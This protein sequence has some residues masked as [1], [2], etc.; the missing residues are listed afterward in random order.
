METEPSNPAATPTQDTAERTGA[1]LP[2]QEHEAGAKAQSHRTGQQSEG[3]EAAQKPSE[4]QT[5]KVYPESK[6]E[7]SKNP[8]NIEHVDLSKPAESS[9]APAPPLFAR[10]D[11]TVAC[12]PVRS[13]PQEAHAYPPET[14]ASVPPALPPRTPE[15]IKNKDA[16][17]EERSRGL[18]VDNKDLTPSSGFRMKLKLA[19]M[20]LKT[21]AKL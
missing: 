21:K 15:N 9:S 13:Q 4:K 20:G 7:L 5:E 16:K 19:W 11:G 10:P 18:D 17:P 14:P 2:R 12:S 1:A 8:A 3:A 6:G